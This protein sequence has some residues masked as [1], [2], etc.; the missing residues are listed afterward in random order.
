MRVLLSAKDVPL[1]LEGE[2]WRF[3]TSGF[4]HL[5]IIHLL[6]N[7]LGQLVIGTAL[8]RVLGTW[9]IIIIYFLSGIDSN[10]QQ[11]SL[12]SQRNQQGWGAQC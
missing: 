5:G 7:L 6:S 1:I 12:H 3:I 11:H 10:R 9:R 2:W 8:E 4:M